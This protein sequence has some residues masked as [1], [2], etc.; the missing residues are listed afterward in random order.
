MRGNWRDLGTETLDRETLDPPDREER[1]KG[2]ERKRGGHE[3]N[4]CALVYPIP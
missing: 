3:G 2:R 1:E 4:G